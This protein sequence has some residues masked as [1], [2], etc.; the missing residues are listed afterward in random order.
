MSGG[1][2]RFQAQYLRRIRC[3]HWAKL[4][5]RERRALSEVATECDQR[6]LDAV[7]LPIFGLGKPEAETI[8]EYARQARITRNGAVSA[9][10]LR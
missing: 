8:C 4:S 5:S 1:F 2:L 10:R 3:P 9:R 7:V 6:E